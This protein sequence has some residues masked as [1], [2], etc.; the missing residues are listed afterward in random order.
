MF[1]Q[2]TSTDSDNDKHVYLFAIA[3]EGESCTLEPDMFPPRILKQSGSIARQ[4]GKYHLI[5]SFADRG[6]LFAGKIL[7]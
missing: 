3:S 6:T 7:V 2:R 5:I 1:S 4:L